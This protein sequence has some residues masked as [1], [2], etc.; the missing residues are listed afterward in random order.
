[1]RDLFDLTTQALPEH[2][3]HIPA[4]TELWNALPKRTR[5]A[6]TPPQIMALGI[7]IGQLTMIEEQN[8]E[9]IA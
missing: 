4:T 2:R 9:A 8:Q 6:W 5:R 7:E 1:M 3:R